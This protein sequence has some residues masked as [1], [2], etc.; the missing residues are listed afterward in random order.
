MPYW[1]QQSSQHWVFAEK[2]LYPRGLLGGGAINFSH[3][4]SNTFKPRGVQQQSLPF[5]WDGS[6]PSIYLFST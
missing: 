6:E 4:F 5:R 3:G 1:M 2:S